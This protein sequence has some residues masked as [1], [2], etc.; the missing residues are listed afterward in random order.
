MSLSFKLI[1]PTL[2]SY[3]YFSINRKIFFIEKIFNIFYKNLFLFQIFCDWTNL[4]GTLFSFY[5]NFNKKQIMD[6]NSFS[7]KT[8]WRHKMTCF[9]RQR[10]STCAQVFRVQVLQVCGELETSS[11][12]FPLQTGAQTQT[13]DGPLHPHRA[14][15][16]PLPPCTSA[17]TFQNKSLRISALLLSSGV[18]ILNL[19]NF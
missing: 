17:S 15:S 1:T 3:L 4:T 19:F 8:L 10:R 12:Q 2:M 11:H 16:S 14:H 9:R 5:F 18:F 7:L 13:G 6:E